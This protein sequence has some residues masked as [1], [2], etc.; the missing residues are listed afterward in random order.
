MYAHANVF[1]WVLSYYDIFYT[2]YGLGNTRLLFS[3]L[4]YV[5]IDT[6]KRYFT[7]IFTSLYVKLY[8]PTLAKIIDNAIKT[9]VYLSALQR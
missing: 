3:Q 9:P 8:L 4:K 5:L 6:K 2:V 7:S 1:L